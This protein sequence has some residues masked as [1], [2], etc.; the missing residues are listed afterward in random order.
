MFSYVFQRWHS[1]IDNLFARH[2]TN[3]GPYDPVNG[4]EEQ[5][6]YN[7]VTVSSV[8]VQPIKKVDNLQPKEN[9]LVTFWEKSSIEL[10]SGLD[11]AAE[12]SVEAHF[13]H[14]Q[15]VPF[16]FIFRVENSTTNEL[17]GTCRIFIGPKNDERNESLKFE[18]QRK[19]MIEMDKFKVF[20]KPGMHDYHRYSTDSS[21]AIPYERAFS[22][23]NDEINKEK[24]ADKAVEAFCGCGWPQHMLLVI[25][26][27][28][29]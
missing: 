27:D 22:A 21:V 12:G 13:I 7:G 5:L 10:K 17:I 6:Q 8:S 26:Y 28:D 20:L 16:S 2:K 24:N 4:E 11:F 25:T 23:K 15:H 3:L 14:L 29:H 9:L 1:F 19:L 18:E